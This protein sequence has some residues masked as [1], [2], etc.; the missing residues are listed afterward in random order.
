[1]GINIVILINKNKTLSSSFNNVFKYNSLKQNLI[2]TKKCS[3]EYEP[4]YTFYVQ[5]STNITYSF[6]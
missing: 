5:I 6:Q 2:T 4:L 1:M 3:T